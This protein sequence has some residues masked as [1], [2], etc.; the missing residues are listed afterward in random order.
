MLLVASAQQLG[1][2]RADVTRLWAR[3]PVAWALMIAIIVAIDRSAPEA[4][5][6]L[7]ALALAVAQLVVFLALATL[8]LAVVDRRALH[9]TR[10]LLRGLG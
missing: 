10:A 4:D 8:V 3:V 5:G 9:E 7:G 1:F 2:R 6:L